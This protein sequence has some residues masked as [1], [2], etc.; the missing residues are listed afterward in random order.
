MWTTERKTEE[1]AKLELQE[2]AAT[3]RKSIEERE[4]TRRSRNNDVP[5]W[6]GA[7]AAL[8]SGVG[9]IVL[10]QYLMRTH[11]GP[12][13]ETVEII[14]ESHLARQ[15]PSGTMTTEHMPNSAMFEG[16]RVLVRCTC[17]K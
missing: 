13:V 2:Q 6:L 1:V 8:V 14:D 3:E 5:I 17:G 7:F 15:C 10:H 11:P 16:P 9:L 4:K 12:C